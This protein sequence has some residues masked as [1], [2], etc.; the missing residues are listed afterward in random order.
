MAPENRT[1]Q[2]R[3]KLLRLADDLLLAM[4]KEKQ[5]N[6]DRTELDEQSAGYL[7]KTEEIHT[8]QECGVDGILSSMRAS[9]W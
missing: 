4:T 3:K 7:E 9:G 5:A 1:P 2:M 6:L 8:M